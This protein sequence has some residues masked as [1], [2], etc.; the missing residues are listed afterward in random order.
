[1]GR[2]GT[3]LTGN[4]DANDLNT[5]GGSWGISSGSIAAGISNLPSPSSGRLMVL[6]LGS[7]NRY[8]QIYITNDSVP[9][10][11]IRRWAAS[12]GVWA[13]LIPEVL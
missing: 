9:V 2:I 3:Q 10:V 12:W 7:E 1:M 4:E 6:P 8:I 13:A 5:I 11:Y